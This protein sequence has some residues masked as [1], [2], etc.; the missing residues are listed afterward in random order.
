M[1]DE[2][3]SLRER[4]V[5]RRVVPVVRTDHHVGDRLVGDLADLLDHPG[6]LLETPLPVGDQ[7]ALAGDHEH[8]HRGE[9]LLASGAELLVGIDAGRE[10][11]DAG[12]IRFGQ[13]ALEGVGGAGRDLGLGG[14]NGFRFRGAAGGKPGNEKQDL[15]QITKHQQP[16]WP[17]G[18]LARRGTSRSY[19]LHRL[20]SDDT[21]T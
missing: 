8:A 12:E 21:I 16:P 17:A 20:R 5:P 6:R 13:P 3:D 15:W 7:H 14:R 2:L 1:H 4:R 19:P 9:E 10:F 18:R 11:L